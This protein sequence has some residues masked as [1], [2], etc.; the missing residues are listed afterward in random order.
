MFISKIRKIGEVE[1][2]ILKSNRSLFIQ[3]KYT[4]YFVQDYLTQIKTGYKT[5]IYTTNPGDLTGT[6]ITRKLVII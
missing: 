2:T 1:K 4:T 5:Y 3:G 6:I